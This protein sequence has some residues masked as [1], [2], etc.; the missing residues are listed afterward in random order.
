ML[1]ELH[2]TAPTADLDEVD[3]VAVE[4]TKYQTSWN[5][6]VDKDEILPFWL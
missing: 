1:N 3:N 4:A 5:S 6:E 2:R